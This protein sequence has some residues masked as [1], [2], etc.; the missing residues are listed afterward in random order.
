V[1]TEVSSDET[2]ESE[3]HEWTEGVVDEGWDEE[4]WMKVDASEAAFVVQDL[5]EGI[6]WSSVRA[7]AGDERLDYQSST[8]KVE[9]R[10][11]EPC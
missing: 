11:Y 3:R 10:E 6:N 5:G 4:V 8:N 7:V 1:W 2:R 9:R